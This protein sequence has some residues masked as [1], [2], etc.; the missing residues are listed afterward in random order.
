[1]DSSF[2]ID[3][4]EN[5]VRLQMRGRLTVQALT[6]AMNRIAMDAQYRSGMHAVAD[7]RECSG[8]W[9][10]SEMQ[11]LRD[12]LVRAGRDRSRRWAVIVKPGALAAIGHVVI[13]ISEAVDASISMRLFEEPEHA[14]RWVRETTDEQADEQADA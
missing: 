13:L 14:L 4:A 7:F 9:D 1:M 10:Y 5:M 2:S 8:E 11:R 12:Y 3:A 6:A